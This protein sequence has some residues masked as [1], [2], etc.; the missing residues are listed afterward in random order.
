MKSG[1]FDLLEPSGPLQPC[2]K[3]DLPLPLP[4][5][6]HWCF[7]AVHPNSVISDPHT[8]ST[9]PVLTALQTVDAR[10]DANPYISLQVQFAV[11]ALVLFTSSYFLGREGAWESASL[12]HNVDPGSRTRYDVTLTPTVKVPPHQS[13]VTTAPVPIRCVASPCIFLFLTHTNNSLPVAIATPRAP[14]SLNTADQNPRGHKVA[15]KPIKAK[16][17][18]SGGCLRYSAW[19]EVYCVYTVKLT[20]DMDGRLFLKHWLSCIQARR[21]VLQSW[22]YKQYLHFPYQDCINY[23]EIA[24]TFP[25]AVECLTLSHTTQTVP[26]AAFRIS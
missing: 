16:E 15:F 8:P 22:Q 2:T 6:L 9:K 10:R 5:H 17:F 1:I 18:Y 24:S 21:T 23:I 13:P 11:R 4:L 26:A 14:A 7:I 25:S 20:T 12:T 3:I 19:S